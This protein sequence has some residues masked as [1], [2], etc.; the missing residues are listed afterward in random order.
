M[1]PPYSFDNN[2]NGCTMT[3]TKSDIIT[4]ITDKYKRKSSEEMTEAVNLIL[5]KIANTLKN[6]ER[7]EIRGF[8]SFRTNDWGPRHARNPITGESWF[9]DPATSVYFKPGKELKVR[10]NKTNKKE[11]G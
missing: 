11:E 8:G 2:S 7:I 10:V 9:T 3:K 5:D 4:A 6:G 1:P